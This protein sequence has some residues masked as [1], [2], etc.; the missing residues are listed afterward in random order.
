MAL[1]QAA[2]LHGH[3]RWPVSFALA[4]A[5]VIYL[6]QDL[7][8]NK[9]SFSYLE[10]IILNLLTSLHYDKI[11]ASFSLPD[12]PSTLSLLE[13]AHEAGNGYELVF[14]QLLQQRLQKIAQSNSLALKIDDLEP[15]LK[16]LSHRSKSKLHRSLREEVVNYIRNYGS[17]SFFQQ[18]RSA[19]VPFEI[20]L[21]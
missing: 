5:I 10:E 13:L 15:C 21:S 1:Q 7:E 20:E 9:V 18:Y 2:Q 8:K 17:S 16:S 11:A 14:F 3:E 6:Q 19:D 12:P 4:D